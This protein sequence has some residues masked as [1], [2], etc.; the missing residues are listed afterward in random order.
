MVDVTPASLWSMAGLAE[1]NATETGRGL[2][3]CPSLT[4]GDSHVE[5]A[6]DNLA[7]VSLGYDIV[8]EL[9]R[10]MRV[11]IPPIDRV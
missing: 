1:G 3:V 9:L 5:V 8:Q 4:L 2:L 6:D 11:P 7:A 10:E